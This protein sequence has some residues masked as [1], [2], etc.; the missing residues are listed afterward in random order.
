MQLKTWADVKQMVEK[1]G[2]KDTDTVRSFSLDLS[3][4]R[5]DF[6]RMEMKMPVERTKSL[7]AR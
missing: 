3:Q 5:D 6:T 4:E 1:S 7:D 2:V